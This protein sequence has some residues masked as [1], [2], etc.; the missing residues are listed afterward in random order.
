MVVL[1][2]SYGAWLYLLTG[3]LDFDDVITLLS[4]SQIKFR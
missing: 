1:W 2:Y 4:Y 3:V